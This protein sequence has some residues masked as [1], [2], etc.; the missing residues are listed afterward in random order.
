MYTYPLAMEK[1]LQPI[2]S[3]VI[4]V[5]SV[6]GYPGI[7][8]LMALESACIPLPSEVIMPFSGYLVF[9][10]RFG[11]HA[12][13]LAGALGCAVG[14]AVAYWVGVYG[15]RPFL[16]KY[17]RYVLIR[18][19]DLDT[20]D[21][22]FNRWGMWAVFISRLLP[23]IRTFI[24]LPAGISRMPFVPF[25]TLSFLGSV[26]WCYLLAYVGQKLGENWE[27]IRSYFHGADAV[28]GIVLGIGFAVWLW[29]HLRP[30]PEGKAS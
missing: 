3:W 18:R 8:L 5:I 26:P 2:I 30:E 23:V 21:R 22:F 10:G 13:S 27:G 6:M 16:E 1:I 9:T 14:S 4:D 7:V 17:G 19:K 12:A 24:S 25:I 11:L 20:A 29:H 28:I 15:G